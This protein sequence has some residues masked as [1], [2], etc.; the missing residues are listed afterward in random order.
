MWERRIYHQHFMELIL[1][2][3]GNFSP[4]WLFESV[5]FCTTKVVFWTTFHMSVA[6]P[7][8]MGY[9]GMTKDNEGGISAY[10]ELE[11][12]RLAGKGTSGQ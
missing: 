2:E 3:S 10:L 5:P 9:V 7:M 12:E 6:A 1:L 4:F 8:N 11:T